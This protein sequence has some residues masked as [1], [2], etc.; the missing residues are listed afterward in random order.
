MRPDTPVPVSENKRCFVG[1]GECAS[2]ATMS[3][4]DGSGG[5]AYVCAGHYDAMVLMEATLESNPD[6]QNKLQRVMDEHY[7]EGA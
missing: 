7:P 3:I 5:V 6:I 1:S 2:I 4:D